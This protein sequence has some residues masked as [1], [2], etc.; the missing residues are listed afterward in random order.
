M[1]GSDV[2]NPDPLYDTPVVL[3]SIEERWADAILA[4]E[5]LWEYRRTAPAIDAPYRSVLYATGDVKAAVGAFETHTVLEEGVDALIEQTVGSAPHDPEDVREYFS[6]KDVGSAI[7]VDAWQRYDEPV[8]IDDLRAGEEFH[9]PQNFRYLQ[10]DDHAQILQQLPH[11]RGLPY[12][13]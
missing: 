1:N 13:Q 10:P 8:P 12:E 4:G 9:T 5:K 6:G 7:R 3:L 2:Q 11:E